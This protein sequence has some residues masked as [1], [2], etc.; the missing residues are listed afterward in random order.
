M[1]KIPLTSALMLI[2]MLQ[3]YPLGGLLFIVLVVCLQRPAIAS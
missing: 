2:P 1:K 3:D